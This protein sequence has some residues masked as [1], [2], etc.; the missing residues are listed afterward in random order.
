MISTRL[1]LEHLLKNTGE[2]ETRK[3]PDDDPLKPPAERARTHARVRVTTGADSTHF[4][5]NAQTD[6][7]AGGN[8]S[9]QTASGSFGSVTRSESV[10]SNRYLLGIQFVKATALEV[11]NSPKLS[12]VN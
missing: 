3:L 6:G 4:L 5:Q 7:S 12:L 9:S 2:P 10:G 8:F 1:F 11:K